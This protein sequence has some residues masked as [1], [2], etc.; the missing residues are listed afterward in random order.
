MYLTST[1]FATTCTKLITRHP[2]TSGYGRHRLTGKWTD[3]APPQR[4]QLRQP[5]A[6]DLTIW[7]C[8]MPT[9]S[10]RLGSFPSESRAEIFLQCRQDC[11]FPPTINRDGF[12]GLREEKIGSKISQKISCFPVSAT[13]SL[14]FFL[15]PPLPQLPSPTRIPTHPAYTPPQIPV[16]P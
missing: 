8:T 14:S 5:A 15:S 3:V 6:A 12:H 7:Q 2:S 1:K 13:F 4:G 16:P 9:L 10:Q 11:P